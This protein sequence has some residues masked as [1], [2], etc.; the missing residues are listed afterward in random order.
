MIQRLVKTTSQAAC[1]RGRHGTCTA[2]R[3]VLKLAA[4]RQSPDVLLMTA[5]IV[6]VIH[7]LGQAIRRVDDGTR[8][9]I[10]I[11]TIVVFRPACPVYT[12]T[13]CYIQKS[14]MCER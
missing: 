3:F 8:P 10:N 6:Y 9:D 13:L 2:R 11:I 7:I 1:C 12:V 4:E 14:G 5:E